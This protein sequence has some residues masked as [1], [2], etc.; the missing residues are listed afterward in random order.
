M[1]RAKNIYEFMIIRLVVIILIC[2]LPHISFSQW[3]HQNSDAN[4]QLT[5]LSFLNKDTGIAVGYLGEVVRTYNGGNTWLTD[6]LGI[7]Y[8]IVDI[9]YTSDNIIYA[10]GNNGVILK[11][12]DGGI[13]WIFLNSGLGQQILRGLHFLNDTVGFVCG[14]GQRIGKT[15]NGGQTWTYQSFGLYWLRELHFPGNEIGFCVGDGGNIHKTVDGGST[16]LHS[17][18][19]PSE[20]LWEVQFTSVDTGFVCGTN[21]TLLRT[22]DSGNSWIQ[23]NAGTTN[24]LLSLSFI[25]SQVG[26][27][28]GTDG[29][30]LFT[31]DG[32]DNWVTESSNT[33]LNLS[34][35][36]M[37]DYEIAYI[38]GQNGTILK[39]GDN[40]IWTVVATNQIHHL[41]IPSTARLELYGVP[42]SS[43]DRLAVF[44]TD[45]IEQVCGGYVDWQETATSI[46]AYG[47]NPATSWKEGFYTNEEFIWKIWDQSEDTLLEPIASYNPSFPNQQLWINGGYSA[48]DSLQMVA[49]SGKVVYN[50]G[51]PLPSGQL[52]LFSVSSNQI[53]LER[54]D[55]IFNGSFEIDNIQSGQYLLHAS[56]DPSENQ[57]L[58]AYYHNEIRWQEAIQ[59]SI[60]AHATS[61]EIKLPERTSYQNGTAKIAGEISGIN[62]SAE[63]F[64]IL[65]FNDQYKALDFEQSDSSG[66]FSFNNLPFSTFYVKVERAGYDSDSVRVDLSENNPEMQ[67]SFLLNDAQIT[68]VSENKLDEYLIYPNPV[69]DILHIN[70]DKV[71]IRT[72]FRIFN[73]SGT[74]MTEHLKLQKSF[75]A[76]QSLDL[77]TLPSGLYILEIEQH[78]KLIRLKIIKN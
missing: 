2:Y 12:T 30:I 9:Q 72:H 75:D 50:D 63:D 18:G 29:L 74:E 17:F 37:L 10:T 46:L 21:G 1:S 60:L 5:G 27:V 11:S 39:K 8:I 53:I 62:I 54:V 32:G 73:L 16:W 45:G 25:N 47:D 13:S 34:E 49:V 70:C 41:V 56:P 36:V 33:T 31:A 65:L 59:V 58:P 38:V 69:N 3:N 42:L 44:F 55:E 43:N 78:N 4:N 23:L 48:I 52:S 57:G 26:Y 28:V 71:G 6:S 77:S 64:T 66:L 7:E 22:T 61:I 35:I 20:E 15:I 40:S 76:I 68:A 24:S 14:Q 51:T 67:L 19:A